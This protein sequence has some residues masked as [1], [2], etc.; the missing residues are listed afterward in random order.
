[1]MNNL[2]LAP[3]HYAD[4]QKS[5]L[6]DDTIRKAGIKSVPPDQINNK[7]GLNI[8]GLMSIYEIPFDDTYSRFRA[9]YEEGKERD[10]KG[11]NK[12]KYL[13][14]KGSGNRLY[15]PS[16][17]T[18]VLGNIY[19]PIDVT[20][21][22]KKALMACQEDLPCIAVTGLW[23]WK[24]KDKNELIECFNKIALDGRTVF[25]TP[26]NDWLKPNS[27]GERKNLKQ[28]VHGLAYL[29]IDRGAKVYWRELPDGN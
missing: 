6:S 10:E 28:A 8:P 4:L 9:F 13:T 29:L 11:D 18:P 16:N 26:D 3:E 1:M 20:E 5:G 17:V 19:V 12:P 23:N 14:K 22:E 27:K 24:V 2:S 15:M 21:G 7:L 25:V